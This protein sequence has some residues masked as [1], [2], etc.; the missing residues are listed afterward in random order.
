VDEIVRHCRAL[1]AGY[2]VPKAVHFTDALPLTSTGKILKR[3]V[4]D[5]YLS[6]R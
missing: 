5:E 3:A 4:R 1:I 6:A 2:K